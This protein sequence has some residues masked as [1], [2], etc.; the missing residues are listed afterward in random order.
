VDGF[1]DRQGTL[2]AAFA[3]Q[4]YRMYPSD[5]GNSSY[6]VSVPAHET[7]API[8][9]LQRLFR[10][11]DYRGIF[12]AEFK[13]DPRDDVFKLIEVNVRPWWYVEFAARCGVDVCYMYYLDALSLPVASSME[14]RSGERLVHAWSDFKAW[15]ERRHADDAAG[16]GHWKAWIGSHRPKFAWDD[17]MPAIAGAL[18]A[19]TRKGTGLFGRKGRR[20]K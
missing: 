18:G 10:H 13:R 7:A 3:R 20:G 15:T 6:M 5:F 19:L 12:S 4:R 11:V 16:W 2:R 8:A 17:P 14:Y 1:I 9:D